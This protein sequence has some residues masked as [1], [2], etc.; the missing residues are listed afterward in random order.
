MRPYF[1]YA[2]LTAHM[3]SMM[4]TAF[5]P[6]LYAWMNESFREQ[7]IRTVPQL[8]WILSKNRRAA[9]RQ[10]VITD[11]APATNRVNCGDRVNGRQKLNRALDTKN[12]TLLTTTNI[13][14]FADPVSTEDIGEAYEL[15]TLEPSSSQCNQNNENH[16]TSNFLQIP[17]GDS[18]PGSSKMRNASNSDIS[19]NLD[20]SRSLLSDFSNYDEF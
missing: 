14:D 20:E 8:R 6:I 5:N 9:T 2:F 16:Q 3:V 13:P 12:K 17:N 19:S 7:F 10:R 1:N 4:A 18:V 15:R 11:C